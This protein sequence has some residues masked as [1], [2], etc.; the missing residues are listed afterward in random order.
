MHNQN[1]A[2]MHGIIQ[3]RSAKKSLLGAYNAWTRTIGILNDE[4]M[5]KQISKQNV[6][7]TQKR[8]LRKWRRAY[9]S[10]VKEKRKCTE[11]VFIAWKG[12]YRIK[13]V[14]TLFFLNVLCVCVFFSREYNLF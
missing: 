6:I 9:I 8:V 11:K 5:T 13:Q 7:L 12:Y 4:R 10:S 2:R 3:M 1:L 14:T